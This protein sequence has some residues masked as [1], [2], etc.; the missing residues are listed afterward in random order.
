MI[1]QRDA[2]ADLEFRVNNLPQIKVVKAQE[3]RTQKA[4]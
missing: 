2:A 4:T 3:Y 1:T